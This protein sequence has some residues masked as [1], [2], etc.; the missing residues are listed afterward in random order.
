MEDKRGTPMEEDLLL[1]PAR[2]GDLL[3]QAQLA[4]LAGDMQLGNRLLG[5]L[6]EQDHRNETAWLWLGSVAASAGERRA[7]LQE[8]LRI[9]PQNRVAAEQLRRLDRRAIARQRI[10][11]EQARLKRVQNLVIGATLVLALLFVGL[12]SHLG[13]G[14]RFAGQPIALVPLYT[15]VAVAARPPAASPAPTTTATLLPTEPMSMPE[16]AATL[17]SETPTPPAEKVGDEAGVGTEARGTE[18]AEIETGDVTEGQSSALAFAVP[19]SGDVSVGFSR[20]HPALDFDA[21]VGTTV[22]A[23]ASGRVVFAGWNPRGSG[24][25]VVISHAGGWESWY[26]HLDGISVSAGDWVCHACPIGTVGNT[27]FSSGPH[28][29]FE[30]RQGCSFYNL[31]TGERLSSGI[32]AN[33]RYD[34]FGAPICLVADATPTPSDGPAVEG[35]P[36]A[37][38]LIETG[39]E[40]GLDDPNLFPP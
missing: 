26:A 4:I 39:G 12:A 17:P 33:Y 40:K 32:A 20:V 2:E 29:H 23:T 6:L 14:E 21:P 36:S 10:S 19:V 8:V 38:D 31:F 34:P 24:N 15:P 27:G 18:G 3:A 28:L 9:N 22:V 11:R 7:C 37:G 30:I 1:P 5:Q 35:P 25:L 13:I 16:P